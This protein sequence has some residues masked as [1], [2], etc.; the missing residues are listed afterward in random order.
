[1][2]KAQ[3]GMIGLAVMG[4][5]LAL[6]VEEHGFSVAVWNFEPERVDSFLHENEGKQFTG[7]KTL[8]DFVAALERP[9]RI[10]MMI[11]AGAPVDMTLDKLAPLLGRGERNL[12]R[13][14]VRTVDQSFAEL[15]KLLGD[16]AEG[17][18]EP[19]DVRIG[20]PAEKSHQSGG[21]TAGLRRQVARR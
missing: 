12:D 20:R 14:H 3:F 18:I 11:K 17:D 4:S 7:T 16:Q 8:E 10:M 5:N 9:R 19:L 1:M 6:N 2:A 21:L 13:R 15:R